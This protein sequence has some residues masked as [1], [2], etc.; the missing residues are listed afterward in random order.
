MERRQQISES[1]CTAPAE[2]Q[3]PTTGCSW[4]YTWRWSHWVGWPA[5]EGQAYGTVLCQVHKVVQCHFPRRFIRTC[6]P[7]STFCQ[8]MPESS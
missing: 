8:F 7:P 1:G 4:T 2:P 5:A 6:G 3:S